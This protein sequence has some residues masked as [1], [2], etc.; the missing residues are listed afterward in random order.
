MVRF[1]SSFE[2]VKGGTLP[3]V[4]VDD[5]VQGNFGWR[6]GG[7]GHLTTTLIGLTRIEREQQQSSLTKK[8]SKLSRPF[9]FVPEQWHALQLI[10]SVVEQTG[11][12]EPDRSSDES[13]KQL[14][15]K[16]S[17]PS[18][19]LGIGS[20]R[21]GAV[22]QLCAFV[23]SELVSTIKYPHRGGSPNVTRSS[24][25]SETFMGLLLSC[26]FGG[27][28]Q[29]WAATEDTHIDFSQVSIFYRHI[30]RSNYVVQ[31]GSLFA[32]VCH[33]PYEKMPQSCIFGKVELMNLF[34][35]A[36]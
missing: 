18:R 3:G 31:T 8:T 36:V 21:D 25:D 14:V 4:W 27:K 26:F 33:L 24:P 1:P 35:V 7:E 22:I 34:L 5:V 17:L 28:T 6:R 19:T 12:I 20:I 11:T 32:Y 2:W 16:R 30:T 29:D 9:Y 10:V 15:S 23:D 13:D